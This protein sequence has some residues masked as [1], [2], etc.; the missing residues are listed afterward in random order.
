MER[1]DIYGGSFNP[2]HVGQ[3]RAANFA[4]E[5]LNLDKLMLIPSCVSCHKTKPENTPSD[6]QRLEMLRLA[7]AGSADLEV[8][9]IELRRG[10]VSYTWETLEALRQQ[11]PDAEFYLCM[12]TD[13]F[14]SF[15]DWK[16]PERILQ[17]AILAVLDRGGKNAEEVALQTEKLETMGARIVFA[18]NP[19]L[20]LSGLKVGESYSGSYFHGL[21]FGGSGGYI[22]SIDEETPLPSGLY[23]WRLSAS[24][25]AHQVFGSSYFK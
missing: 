11:Y 17:H 12:G 18:D 10:G 13:M 9:D 15:H 14:L 24:S 6:A 19:V 5:A 3:L 25:S 4:K 23:I 1:I 2:L 21:A 22:F 8:C 20:D 7:V 16:Y